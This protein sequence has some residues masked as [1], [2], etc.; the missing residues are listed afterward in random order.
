M[1][2]K[3]RWKDRMDT[4]RRTGLALRRLREESRVSQMAL[5]KFIGCC[6]S[7]ISALELGKAAS[8]KL[9]EAVAWSLGLELHEIH[10]GGLS[11]ISRK[12]AEKMLAE[13]QRKRDE[14]E[15]ARANNHVAVAWAKEHRRRLR[16]AG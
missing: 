5:A 1:A 4:Q 10:I 13:E 16:A 14:R 8:L 15:L 3:T 6:Q 7:S 12:R 11:A 9:A 2:N